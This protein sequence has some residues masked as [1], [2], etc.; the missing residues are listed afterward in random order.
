VVRPPAWVDAQGV[1]FQAPT[2]VMDTGLHSWHRGKLQRDQG[3]MILGRW[4]ELLVQLTPGSG[5]RD[6][7]GVI[8]VLVWTGQEWPLGLRLNLGASCKVPGGGWPAPRDAG[9][10]PVPFQ[11]RR[12]AAKG[13]GPHD[14]WLVGCP[15]LRSAMPLRRLVLLWSV[16]G[17]WWWL[18]S[19]LGAAAAATP[20]GV[21]GFA[22]NAERYAF[23]GSC[24]CWLPT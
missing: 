8:S 24:F 20:L 23:R 5:Q 19:P 2:G 1:H 22:F 14:P 9:Y 16:G 7:C 17:M 15:Q 3:L 13:P 10:C 21:V 12:E 11:S 6:Q 4:A 18:C